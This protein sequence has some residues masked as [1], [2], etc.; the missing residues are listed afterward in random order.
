MTDLAEIGMSPVNVKKSSSGGKKK[1]FTWKS[2]ETI[3]D[4]ETVVEK[5]VKEKKEKRSNTVPMNDTNESKSRFGSLGRKKKKE[6][7]ITPGTNYDSTPDRDPLKTPDTSVSGGSSLSRSGSQRNYF[8]PPPQAQDYIIQKQKS[9]QQLATQLLQQLSALQPGER[10]DWVDVE[11]AVAPYYKRTNQKF[12]S[13]SR[14][15]PPA[16]RNDSVERR[17]EY[18]NAEDLTSGFQAMGLD[19]SS[20]GYQV[21]HGIPLADDRSYYEDDTPHDADKPNL[22]GGGSTSAAR[23]LVVQSSGAQKTRVLFRKSTA[24]NNSYSSGGSRES[25]RWSMDSSILERTQDY[26]SSTTNINT[27]DPDHS[28]L[29]QQQRSPSILVPIKRI[30]GTSST[31]KRFSEAL[32]IESRARLSHQTDIIEIFEKS[33]TPSPEVR[34]QWTTFT[35]DQQLLKSLILLGA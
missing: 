11:D 27:T 26:P 21:D 6:A 34:N 23:R 9:Q 17:R 2:R 12:G 14:G 33:F 35:L 13:L 20:V 15:P 4:P 29:Q 25:A 32:S 22:S 7:V 19:A 28:P 16:L 18:E 31:K 30:S 5:P 10:D 1:F 8:P 24:S 3:K